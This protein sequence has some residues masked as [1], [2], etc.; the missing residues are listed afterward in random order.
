M[1]R[2]TRRAGARS[3]G[4]QMK[5]WTQRQAIG[6]GMCLLVGAAGVSADTVTDKTTEYTNRIKTAETIQPLGETPFGEQVG[7]YNGSLGFR[8]TD[9]SY[10]GIG[11]TIQLTR[12]YDITGSPLGYRSELPMADWDL[13]VPQIATIVPGVGKAGGGG[14]WI[15]QA[16]GDQWARCSNIAQ[17]SVYPYFY[18]LAWWHGYQLVTGDGNSQALLKRTSQNTLAP[19]ANPSAYPI[20]TM[21]HWMISCLPST[22]N[23]VPGEAFLATSP[24]GTRYWFDHFAFG[25]ALET[26]IE[27]ESDT[28]PGG[29]DRVLSS[30]SE[31]AVLA[32]SATTGD[33]GSG[34]DGSGDGDVEPDVYWG[35][36]KYH[37]PRRR[38]HLLVR[39]VEDRF[40]NWLKYDYDDA[41]RLQDIKASDGRWVQVVW[42]KDAPVIDRIRLQPDSPLVREWRY[43]YGEVLDPVNR[44]LARV[45]QPDGS[46]WVLEMG[47]SS[48][49]KVLSANPDGV[50]HL[51]TLE[52][53]APFTV[54][55]LRHPSGLYGTFEL[56]MIG[57]SR[58]WVPTG[59]WPQGGTRP[60]AEQ[61]PVVFTTLALT[62]K[63]FSGAGTDAASWTFRYS[64]PLGSTDAECLANGCVATQWTEVV[65]PS[66]AGIRYTFSNRFDESEGRLLETVAGIAVPGQPTAVGLQVDR[67]WFAP[68]DQ[69][70]FPALVGQALADPVGQ[71]NSAPSVVMTLENLHETVRQGVTFTRRTTRFDRFGQPE[72]ITRSSSLGFASNDATTYWPVTSQWVLGQVAQTTSDGL[73]VS[74]TDYDARMLPSRSLEHGLL[75]ALFSWHQDGTLWTV[76]DARGN[77]TTLT[78]HYRGVP[79]TIAFPDGRGIGPSAD[80]FGQVTAVRN[81][82]GHATTYQYDAMGRLRQVDYP[83]GDSVAWAPTSR[84]FTPTT[85]EEFGLYGLQWKQEVQTGSGRTTTYFNARWL[86]ALTITEDT[87]RSSSRSFQVKRYDGMGRE[88][89]TAYPVGIVASI[90]SPMDGVATTYDALGRP[91]TRTQASELGPL[92]T[93][94]EY[95]EGFVTRETNPRGFATSTHFQAFDTPS[96]EHPV[97]IEAPKG[98]LTLIDRDGFGKPKSITRSGPIN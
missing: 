2:P 37:M 12:S 45:V 66:G 48:V 87:A 96:T 75:K 35:L 16:S 22:S 50:C 27:Y 7:L 57:R 10:P 59:C 39:W 86:P 61:I 95:L 70:P 25:G 43:E 94:Y 26:L 67:S 32:A 42:R 84:K 21:G 58:S 65:D 3:E 72:A 80:T 9:I 30:I 38:A 47:G 82:L 28:G 92:E 40:G 83:T 97:R 69:G 31:T 36:A 88:V 41:G 91:M 78:N 68:R 5:S 14:H 11:P 79:Q 51:R 55:R 62:R 24:D 49:A 1:A 81:Q 60:P 90:S 46:D 6:L 98:V 74:Q 23:G 17:I 19:G 15:V 13:S 85:A 64:P 77:T 76:T 71:S 73:V 33:G 29:V 8:H 34:G 89:F 18:G 54:A 93:R 4:T 53:S 63:T 52:G 44:Y 56:S 20:V